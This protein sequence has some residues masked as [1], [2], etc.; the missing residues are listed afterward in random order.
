MYAELL[1]FFTAIWNKDAELCRGVVDTET[2]VYFDEGEL[3]FSL[4]GLHQSLLRQPAFPALSYTDFR[5][6]LYASRLNSDLAALGAQISNA[7]QRKD[8]A[9]VKKLLVL[10]KEV[11]V[12]AFRWRDRHIV[13]LLLPL[14]PNCL[15]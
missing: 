13:L 3:V 14:L 4:V 2:N 6:R 12:V 10:V 15:L 11:E 5:R 1:G 8:A 7:Q 9:Q